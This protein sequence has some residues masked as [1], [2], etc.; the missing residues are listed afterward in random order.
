M[1]PP[2]LHPPSYCLWPGCRS[3]NA[4]LKDV[5]VPNDALKFVIFNFVTVLIFRYKRGV[6]NSCTVKAKVR[7]G[8]L[9]PLVLF[10]HVVSVI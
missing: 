4:M 5:S 1:P 10:I 9:K 3:H 2:L 7:G 8:L 6:T